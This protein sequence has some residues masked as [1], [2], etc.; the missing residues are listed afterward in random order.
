MNSPWAPGYDYGPTPEDYQA[1]NALLAFGFLGGAHIEA[2][3][4]TYDTRHYFDFLSSGSIGYLAEGAYLSAHLE[5]GI[6]DVAL[7]RYAPVPIPSAIVLFVSGI[8]SLMGWW[9]VIKKRT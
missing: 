6:Q 2:V 5:W 4:L 8:F 9:H 7:A 3:D 1:Y